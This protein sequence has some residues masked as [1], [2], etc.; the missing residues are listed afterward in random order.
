[1]MTLGTFSMGIGDRFGHQGRAQLQA[2]IQARRDGQDVTP[3]WNKSHR[4]HT[5][6]ATRP[7]AVRAEADAAVAALNWNA[8]YFVDADHIGIKNV[9]L[10]MPACDFFTLDVADFA[11]ECAADEALETFTSKYDRLV[12]KLVIPG[13]ERPLCVSAASIREIAENYLL[14]VQ[15]AGRIYRH[16]EAKLGAGNFVT[17]VSMDEADDPQSPDELIFILAMLAH[18]GIPVQTLAPKFSGRFNKGVDYIGDVSAFAREFEEDVAVVA[19]AV[20]AFGLP[21]DLK[22]SLHSGSDKFSIY[23]VIR[24]V[25]TRFGAGLHVKTAGTTW[26]EEIIGLACAGGDGLAIAR[27][28]Y[29]TAMERFEELVAPYAAV[30]DVNR[31]R[32]PDPA[33]V[34]NWSSEQFAAALRHDPDCPH[35]NSDFRQLIHVA[36]R[37]A[38]EMGDRYTD[39]LTR[40]ES[41]I[42]ANVTANLYDRH[43]KR[44]FPLA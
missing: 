4:E 3:V 34:A 13:I 20:R 32:L 36:Y 17:E 23:P 6:V 41:D 14:A 15:E 30:L 25:L 42:A 9:D 22:L 26:L 39:A 21:P 19:Y 18:E 35:Y 28:V 8:P 5:I 33:A 7:D 38:A 11:G 37:V 10:F 31:S 2:M 16:I 12:G 44:V 27:S 40:F 43:I 1:M 29:S 24:D